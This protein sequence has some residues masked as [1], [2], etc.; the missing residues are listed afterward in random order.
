M[1][2]KILKINA[3]E[4]AIEVDYDHKRL[5]SYDYINKEINTQTRGVLIKI[6]SVLKKII[7]NKFNIKV[8]DFGVKEFNEIIE[9]KVA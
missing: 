8:F 9:M 7:E 3:F 2:N 1:K 5:L 6:N 4:I